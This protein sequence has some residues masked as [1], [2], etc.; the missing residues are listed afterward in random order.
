[1]T[2]LQLWLWACPFQRLPNI[3]HPPLNEGDWTGLRVIDLT[4]EI[5]ILPLE[6][7]SQEL[8]FCLVVVEWGS[9]QVPPGD[10]CL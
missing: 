10:P 9:W 6:M 3:L 7:G 2:R 1:M 4:G 5:L 8:S